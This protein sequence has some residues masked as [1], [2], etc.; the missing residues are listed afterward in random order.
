ML[1][2]PESVFPQITTRSV[3]EDL[4]QG[5]TESSLTLRV[6]SNARLAYADVNCSTSALADDFTP[7][8]FD[9]RW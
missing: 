2:G 5:P 1:S 9:H 6:M 7:A 4:T 3:S 8:V